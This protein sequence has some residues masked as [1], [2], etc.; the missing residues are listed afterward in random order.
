M[1]RRELLRRLSQQ[2]CRLLR[3]GKRHSVWTNPE[4]G[5]DEAIPRHVEIDEHLARKILKL[6]SSEGQ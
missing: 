2:G 1:K 6:M 3:E 4:T 5:H